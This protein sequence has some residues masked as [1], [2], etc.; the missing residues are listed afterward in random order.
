ML[1]SGAAAVKQPA[2]LAAFADCGAFAA[3]LQT[4]LL[5][6]QALEL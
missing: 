1:S 2:T 5:G 6:K 4:Q 3:Q